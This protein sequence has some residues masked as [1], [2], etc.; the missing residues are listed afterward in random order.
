MVDRIRKVLVANR[1]EIAVRIIRTCRKLGIKTVAIYTSVDS[2][3]MHVKLADDAYSLGSNPYAYL[4]I[5]RISDIAKKSSVDAVHPGYGFLSENSRFAKAVEDVGCVWIGPP[6]HVMEMLESKTVVKKLAGSIGVPTVPGIMEL[7]SIGELR[8]AVEKIGFPLLLKAD[9]GGGG[10]G[11]RIVRSIEEL[12]RV[13]DL[14]REEVRTAFGS[15]K[16]FIEKYI[17]RARHIELQILSDR[18]GNVVVMGERECSIQRKYQKVI[19][20][21]PSP[22]VSDGDR[23][24]LYDLAIRFMRSIGY[25]NAGTM[26]FIRDEQGRFYLIEVNKRIQVEHPVTEMITGIDIVEHQI[27]IAEGRELEI[28]ESVYTFDGHAIEARVYAEDP[29]RLIPSPGTITWIEFPNLSNVRIDHAL[30]PGTTIPPFYDP[31]IAKVIARGATREEARQRLVQALS[32]FRIEG[33]KTSIP[34]LIKILTFSEFI[35][36][37]THTEFMKEF[38]A[39]GH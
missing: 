20:E 16:L 1:G 5:G 31:M 25:V 13:F 12:E 27:K 15:D 23:R 35:K 3:A 8:S 26:E 30:S 36:G 28:R 29:E 7:P 4:D 17:P 24:Y 39:G 38:I 14:A 11:I 10:R 9:R 34:L 2:E 22:I 18:Y 19:E 37:N 6:W 32:S 33:I 21:A